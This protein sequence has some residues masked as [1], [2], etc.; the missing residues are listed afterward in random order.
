VNADA[1]EEMTRFFVFSR[2]FLKKESHN[3]KPV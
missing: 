2:P 3:E 1:L